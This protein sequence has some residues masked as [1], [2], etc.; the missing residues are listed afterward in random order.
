M[1]AKNAYTANLKQIK[2]RLKI[3]SEHIKNKPVN[4]NINWED[5]GD[6]GY[7]NNELRNIMESLNLQHK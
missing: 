6:T 4:G 5:V 7:I 3:I 1:T 2:T